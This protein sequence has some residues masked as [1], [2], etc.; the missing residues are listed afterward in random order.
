M[1]SI[2]GIQKKKRFAE[3]VIYVQLAFKSK[4]SGLVLNGLDN[5]TKDQKS[6]KNVNYP[7]IIKILWKV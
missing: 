6:K 4:P 7:K 5:V 3:N 2:E 1:I